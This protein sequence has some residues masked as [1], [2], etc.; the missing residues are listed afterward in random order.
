MF[1]VTSALPITAL[2][3]LVALTG[4]TPGT[5]LIPESE[6]DV[7][8]RELDEVATPDWS[9][10][11]SLV[12]DPAAED[13]VVLAYSKD[14]AGSLQIGAW[15]ATTG[16][17]LWSDTAVTG[18]V[19]IGVQ[20]SATIVSDGDKHYAAYLRPGDD[21]GWQDM[22]LAD[23]ATGTVVPLTDNR[24]WA[25]SRPSSCADGTDV[26]F[27][28]WKQTAY[29]AG[30]RSYRFSTAGGEIAP[31][32]DVQIPASAR[33]IGSRVYSTNSRPPEGVELLGSSADGVTLWERP[34]QD[35]FGEGSSSDSG[36]AWVT[37]E[38][39]ELLIGS[40]SVSDP[41]PA[42]ATEHTTD[43]TQQSIVAL[44][45]DSGETVWTLDGAEFCDSDVRADARADGKR[46]F[47]VFNSGTTTIV[48]KADGSGYD[49]TRADFDVDLVGVDVASGEIDWT[50]PL[51]GDDYNGVSQ[52]DEVVFA[53]S[54]ADQVRLVDGVSTIVNVITGE[55]T[56]ASEE[57][58]YACSVTRE[59]L[60]ALYP[61]IAEPREFRGGADNQGCDATG[62]LTETF[63]IGSV[64]MVGVDAGAG[65]LVVASP[66]ALLGFTLED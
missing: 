31:D 4:C 14:A 42:E 45:P 50:L 18:A 21:E 34:Y 61:G 40:G 30:N 10:D 39:T 24:V 27:T 35:V 1:R 15:D 62:K 25:T 6:A 16:A 22:V 44:D 66:G 64:R 59:P 28:G 32:N 54:S 8:A 33:L 53:S 19:T 20:A 12:G 47:C 5:G 37:E 52:D 56:D 46:T 51:G 55:H 41:A 26:C 57:A 43:A 36:W 65:Y 9:V 38:T 3:L 11:A 23:L 2:V 58:V 7:A 49:I 17:P 63:S 60:I 13:G 48:K 29:D